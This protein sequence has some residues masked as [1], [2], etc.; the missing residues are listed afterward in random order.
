MYTHSYFEWIYNHAMA[1][2]RTEKSELCGYRVVFSPK[3]KA[4]T[5]WLIAM[6]MY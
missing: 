5:E 6:M 4:E 2:F 1:I 3:L